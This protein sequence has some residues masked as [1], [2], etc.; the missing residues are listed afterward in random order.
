[1]ITSESNELC[2]PFLEEDELEII[3]CFSQS[4]DPTKECKEKEQLIALVSRWLRS[5]LQTPYEASFRN[6]FR[7]KLLNIAGI[8]TLLPKNYFLEVFENFDH[9]NIGL[10]SLPKNISKNFIYEEE[11]EIA[12]SNLDC[13]NSLSFFLKIM[14]GDRSFL[15]FVKE[16]CHSILFTKDLSQ[17]IQTPNLVTSSNEVLS[18][19][20]LL[21]NQMAEEK[22]D[23]DELTICYDLIYQA[24][25]VHVYHHPE[26]VFSEEVCKKEGLLRC[27][28]FSTKAFSILFSSSKVNKDYLIYIQGLIRNTVFQ[29]RQLNYDV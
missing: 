8:F 9:D 4:E 12:A 20:I 21:Q 1:M 5:Y 26:K 24:S 10:P 23:R 2:F 19:T 6:L 27:L 7:R 17:E 22:A 18:K 3:E 29:L 25:F 28:D 11:V 15:D 14:E 13:F 16:N